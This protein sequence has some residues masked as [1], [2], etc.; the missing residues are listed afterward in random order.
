MSRAALAVVFALS[1]SQSLNAAPPVATRGNPRVETLRR[2]RIYLPDFEA[3]IRAFEEQ[4]WD[5]YGKD[6]L[7]G[8]VDLVVSVRELLE[9][10]RR[11]YA[12]AVIEVGRPLAQALAELHGDAIPAGYK[13]LAGINQAMLDLQTAYPT[14]CQRVDL[15]QYLGTT[16]T[17]QNRSIYALKISDNVAVDEDEPTALIASCHHAREITTPEAALDAAGYLL[18]NYGG[19]TRS[20]VDG[21][22][23]WIV[24]VANPDGYNQV[25]TVDNLWRKNL[26]DTCTGTA[27]DGVDLNRNYPK[28]WATCGGSTNACD[29]QLYR[30]PSA[31]SEP[32]TQTMMALAQRESFW[33]GI[34]YH[35]YG[36]EVLWGY[37]GSASCPQVNATLLPPII[38]TR[39]ALMSA[40]G[41][42]QRGPSA[43]GESYQWQYNQLGMHAYLIEIGTS[44]Q[45]AWSTVAGLVASLRPGIITILD[46]IEGA[47]IRGHVTSASGGAPLAATVAI[48]GLFLTGGEVRQSA[49]SDGSYRWMLSPGPYEVTIGKTGYRS[50]TAHVYVGSGPVVL[51]VA[52]AP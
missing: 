8:S 34:D 10:V 39:N 29:Y 47:Q 23:I 4:G 28:D 2:V 9:L 12:P 43:G 5:V 26:R 21:N 20:Y 50:Q 44:F 3:E 38:E 13:D 48:R 35:S 49:A 40:I 11:G 25:V 17:W 6:A 7:A 1:M 30:G 46:R 22:E 37:Y 52:L 42:G 36:N 41:Y 15:N 18:S 14:L 19:S 33:V 51:D 32:E 27:N 24:P 16:K 31:A 45:P